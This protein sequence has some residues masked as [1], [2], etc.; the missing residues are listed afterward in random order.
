[1]TSPELMNLS[2]Y[3]SG[4]ASSLTGNRMRIGYTYPQYP[5][6]AGLF[7][8]ADDELKLEDIESLTPNIIDKLPQH[9]RNAIEIYLERIRALKRKNKQLDK[10]LNDDIT[11]N[12]KQ[13]YDTE[14]YLYEN[15]KILGDYVKVI[16]VLNDNSYNN[17]LDTVTMRN[18]IENLNK[19]S[20][21]TSRIL[22]SIQG[23][24]F[25]IFDRAGYSDLGYS[26]MSSSKK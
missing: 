17:A 22:N 6:S 24:L 10:K 2:F 3:L 4:L 9:T 13:L 19:S 5:F 15:L 11:A 18:A 20:Q 7:G 25:N 14:K 23:K 8:G 16:N 21:S 12:I 1:M 26:D